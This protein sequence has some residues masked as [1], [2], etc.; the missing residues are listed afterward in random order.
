M[1]KVKPFKAI[2]PKKGLEERIAAL[3]YDVYNREE[4]KRE[5]EKEPLSFLKI[6]RAETQ[7]PDDV[8]TYADCVYDKAHEL[9]WGMIEHGE[10]VKE[11]EDSYY[12]YEL[13]MDGRSQIGITACASVDDYI[14]QTIK[15]HENTREDKE[16]DRI[17][18][19]E[20]G[21]AHV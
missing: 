10:F 18:H 21:R 7:F 1:A 19:V 11:K 5:V 6:D 20:I 17:R 16:I 12:V 9:L 3:P 14:N 8:S 15:K 2:R 13:I 4:A